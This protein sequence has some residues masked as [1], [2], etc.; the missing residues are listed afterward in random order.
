MRTLA[1]GDPAHGRVGHMV[2]VGQGGRVLAGLPK[3]FQAGRYHS[4]H[5]QESTLPDCLAITARLDDHGPVA[6]GSGQAKADGMIMALEHRHLPVA[7]VQFHPESLLT[8]KND[9]GR[10][11]VANVMASL[12]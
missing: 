4:L 7:G 1:L 2:V 9:A 5:A 11:L 6:G 10:L 8:C 3:Q 12:C